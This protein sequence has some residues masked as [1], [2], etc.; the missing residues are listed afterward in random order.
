[1]QHSTNPAKIPSSR[2]PAPPFLG[3]TFDYYYY[4]VEREPKEIQM[5]IWSNQSIL[6]HIIELWSSVEDG[7]ASCGNGWNKVKEMELVGEDNPLT[8]DDSTQS[9]DTTIRADSRLRR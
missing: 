1:M 7:A 5:P 6:P 2:S 9:P 8:F 4:T 3:P